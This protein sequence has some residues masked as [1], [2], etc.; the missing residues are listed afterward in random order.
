LLSVVGVKLLPPS[1]TLGGSPGHGPT[2][3]T[4]GAGPEHQCVNGSPGVDGM[5]SCSVDAD[6]GGEFAAIGSCQLKANCSFGPPIPV[7]MGGLSACVV[8]TF[9]TDLCGRVNL[10]PP[11]TTLTTALS[12][13][14]YVTANAASPCPRCENGVCNGGDRAGLSCTAV[15]SAQTSLDCPPPA[16]HFLAA[17]TVVLP[18]LTTG[19]ST[20][21]SSDGFFCAEQ[22]SAGA[23]GVT[24]ARSITEVGVPPLGSANLLAMHLASTFCVP[25]TGTIL[26]YLA[27][28]PAPG[29]LSVSGQLD[30]RGVL[31]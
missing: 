18:S 25:A 28:L 13:R 9:L 17:L 14:V 7:P 29:A 10:L 16:T 23:F 30:L 5:G 12:S 2:D 8:S 11:Q 24:A 31:P 27:Q 15:G 20:L 21:R 26:D 19:K 1:V 4:L 6:C 3:C 22:P